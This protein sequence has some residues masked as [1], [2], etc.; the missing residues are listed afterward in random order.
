MPKSVDP[1]RE[2]RVNRL[3]AKLA[4]KIKSL[5]IPPRRY[6]R[7]AYQRLREQHAI[8]WVNL[9]TSDN[10]FA[11]FAKEGV[12]DTA[13]E[14]LYIRL[15]LDTIVHQ[16]KRGRRIREVLED[17]MLDVGDAV[18]YAVARKAEEADIARRLR[19]SAELD[20]I[21]EPLYAELLSGFLTS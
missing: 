13:A 21:N 17:P 4:A 9:I 12:Q 10:T 16:L 20:L 18:R 8:V 11:A 2:K 19:K 7:W 15:Q 6:V 5:G 3:W 1:E 14:L